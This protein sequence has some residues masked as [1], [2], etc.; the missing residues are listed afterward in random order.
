MLRQAGIQRV[1][2]GRFAARMQVAI[3]ND[4]PVTILLDTDEVAT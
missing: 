2:M 1:E 3:Y 4:G